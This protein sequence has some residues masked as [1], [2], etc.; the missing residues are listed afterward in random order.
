MLAA[1]S[2]SADTDDESVAGRSVSAHARA[3]FEEGGQ[4]RGDVLALPDRGGDHDEAR[5]RGP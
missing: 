5:A 3:E 4:S 1:E 2:M